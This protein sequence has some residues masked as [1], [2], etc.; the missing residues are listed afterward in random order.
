MLGR[1]ALKEDQQRAPLS[2]R[3]SIVGALEEN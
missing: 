3:Y 1:F 2:G